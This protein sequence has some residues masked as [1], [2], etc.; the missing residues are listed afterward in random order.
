MMNPFL[1]FVLLVLFVLFYFIFIYNRL[2]SLQKA[3]ESAWSDIEV[4][5]KRRYNLVPALVATIKGYKNYEAE[6]LQNVIEARSKAL[7]A[8]DIHEKME[9]NSLLSRA[10]GKLF[11]LVENYPDLKASTNFLELQKELAN[12]END[13]Q[14]ARR[15]Y[16]AVVRDY[17]TRLDSF[18]D[19]FIAKRFGFKP[20]EYFEVEASEKEK[21][22]R[23]PK[24]EFE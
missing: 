19:L 23:M 17:N 3:A 20:K 18:P 2:V 6:T 13:I 10:L 24:I 11:A 4:Q 15:Y 21:I 9:A 22:T 8:K 7:G 12:I 5:L 1:I 16:N 14:N